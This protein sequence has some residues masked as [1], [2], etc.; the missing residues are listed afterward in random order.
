MAAVR[1][2]L[3]VKAAPIYARM[4]GQPE[5]ASR[6]AD[7]AGVDASAI[8]ARVNAPGPRRH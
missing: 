7:R 2:R 3:V 5:P 1:A 8:F 6:A 4:N